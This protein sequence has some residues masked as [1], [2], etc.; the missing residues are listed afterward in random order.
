MQYTLYVHTF[1]QYTYTI[2][3]NKLLIMYLSVVS[4]L[5]LYEERLEMLGIIGDLT[6][7]FHEILQFWGNV[8]CQISTEDPAIPRNHVGNLIHRIVSTFMVNI[9]L[10]YIIYSTV[11]HIMGFS[12]ESTNCMSL[13]LFTFQM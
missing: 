5:P 13:Q 4:P 7:Y 11:Y 10:W 8:S 1:T 2:Y 12:T 3:Y 6:L 9:I